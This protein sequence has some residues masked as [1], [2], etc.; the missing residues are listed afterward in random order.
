MK[1]TLKVTWKKNCNRSDYAKSS[2]YKMRIV[3]VM[4][5]CYK[6]HCWS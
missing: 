6:K 2:Y 4:S 3:R 1:T 5:T